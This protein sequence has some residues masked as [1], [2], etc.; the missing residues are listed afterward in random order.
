MT[1]VVDSDFKTYLLVECHLSAAPID[2]YSGDVEHF[3]S[4]VNHRS[5]QKEDVISFLA[6]LTENEYAKT[7]ITRKMS[8]IR[9]YFY[10]LKHRKNTDVP[11]IGDVFKPNR[12]L[13][14]PKVMSQ[15]CLDRVLGHAFNESKTPLRDQCI[16]ALLYYGGCRVSEV[17]GL[18]TNHVF[19]EHLVIQGKGGKERVV[20]LAGPLINA[21]DIYMHSERKDNGSWV[22][23][24]SKGRA[25]SRQT[26]TGILKKMAQQ[27]GISE[28]LT[29]HMMRHV[30]N[31]IIGARHGSS[32]SSVIIGACLNYYHA[33]VY[34]FK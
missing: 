27:L 2:A 14:L 28:R 3:K 18:D 20:Q 1:G 33:S 21:L 7:S 5:P 30:C 31:H 22:F 10:Y 9:M 32:R 17:V 11:D 16:V 12:A 34:P 19:S 26:V 8:S 13:K 23:P 24:G 25:L 15:E 4:T 29:P 6:T